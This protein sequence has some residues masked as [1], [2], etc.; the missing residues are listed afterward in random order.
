MEETTKSEPIFKFEQ[1]QPVLYKDVTEQ[2]FYISKSAVGTKSSMNRYLITDVDDYNNKIQDVSESDLK[3]YTGKLQFSVTIR[4]EFAKARVDMELK[5]RFSD[6]EVRT[7]KVYMTGTKAD[8]DKWYKETVET[9]TT[10]KVIGIEYNTI[11]S[12]DVKKG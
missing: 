11:R 7:G 12:K 2:V 10:V 5:S 4:G 3:E 9:D 8:F 6:V 1:G